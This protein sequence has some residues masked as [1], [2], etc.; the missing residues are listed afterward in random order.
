MEIVFGKYEIY[1][2]ISINKTKV[3]SEHFLESGFFLW[4]ENKCISILILLLGHAMPYTLFIH[5]TC[6][7]NKY[8]AIVNITQAGMCRATTEQSLLQSPLVWFVG[9]LLGAL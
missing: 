5:T 1:L 9:I 8:P 6:T 3:L 7:K 4:M 2:Y